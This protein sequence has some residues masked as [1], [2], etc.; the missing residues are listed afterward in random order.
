MKNIISILLIPFIISYF[1]SSVNFFA[2]L[3]YYWAKVNFFIFGGL[4]FILIYMLFFRKRVSR[5]WLIFGHEF[6]HLIF[7]LLMFRR[8]GAFV[9]ESNIGG[10]IGY[11]RSGNFLI[12]PAP[13]FF[14]TFTV[15]LLLLKPAVNNWYYNYYQFIMGLSFGFHA[16]MTARYARPWQPDFQE[17]GAFFGFTFVLLMNIICTTVIFVVLM[18]NWGMA[19]IYL[20][21]G[22]YALYS[23]F[24]SQQPEQNQELFR[25]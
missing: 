21:D 6:T 24:F 23:F 1:Y 11:H 7:A 20:K 8:P 25:F 14:P 16:V 18:E 13:Y 3:P 10:Y 15:F 19:W 5:F 12:A 17:T 22:C 2:H 4:F 9:V